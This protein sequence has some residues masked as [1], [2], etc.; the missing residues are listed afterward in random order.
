MAH[1]CNHEANILSKFMHYCLPYLFGVRITGEQPSIVHQALFSKE[2]DL[3]DLLLC[4]DW[5]EVIKQVVCGLE[6]LHNRHKMLQN[7]MKCD[8]VVLTVLTTPP[9]SIRA[10][11]IDF[12]KACEISKGRRCNLS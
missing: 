3:K 1:N 9:S 6:H 8:N 5:A 4:I 10:V 7:D 12:G 11:I 2:Q